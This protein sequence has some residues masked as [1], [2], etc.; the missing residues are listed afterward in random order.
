MYVTHVLIQA[1][2]MFCQKMY[3]A[4]LT[5]NDWYALSCNQ[6]QKHSYTQSAHVPCI[7]YNS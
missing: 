3:D 6:A 2:Q 5:Y 1:K 7:G 4:L